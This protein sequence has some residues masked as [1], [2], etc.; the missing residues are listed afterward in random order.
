MEAYGESAGE[1]GASDRNGYGGLCRVLS[2][3]CPLEGSRGIPDA[4]RLYGADAEWLSAAGAA[5]I[6]RPDQYEDYAEIL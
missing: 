6:H 5:G 4:A 3:I 1:H 2:G